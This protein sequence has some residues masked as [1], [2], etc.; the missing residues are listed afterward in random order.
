[1]PRTLRPVWLA[2]LAAGVL[3]AMLGALGVLAPRAAAQSTLGQLASAAGGR[4]FGTAVSNSA[5]TSDTTYTSILG[6][7]FSAVTPENA[8]KWDTVEPNQGQFDFSGGDQL[9]SYAKQHN[10]LVRGH[11]L[12]WHSQLPGWVS[13]LPLNQVQAA[14]ENHITQEVSHYKGSI[15]AWDVVNEPFNDDGS[16][17]SDVFYQA[18]GTGYIADALRTAHAADPS[19]K[20]YLNDYNIEGT[21]AKADAMYNLV[22]SLKAQGVP[23]DG[24]GFETHLAIQYGF[25]TGMQQNLQRFAALGVDVAI[26]ELDVRMTLPETSAQDTTQA[27]YY[28][29]VTNACLAVS[30]CVGITVWEFT[31]KYSWVPGTFSG[32][33]AADLYDSNYQTKPAY[34]AVANDLTAAAGGTTAPPTTAPPT[35]A[36][37]TTAPPTTAPPTTPPGGSGCKASYAVS[38]DWGSGFTANVTVANTGSADTKSWK[39]SWSWP[40]NQAVVNMW[41]AV[42]S[43]SGTAVT[44]TSQSYNA[45]IPP[46]GSTS[47]G[48]QATYSGG[49]TAPTLTCTAG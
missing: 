45:D 37:P 28:S 5:L 41:N 36:P 33:G 17:R 35:T 3:L 16:Y 21:G 42:Y 39:V 47:F 34:T 24:V 44:A 32:Q 29:Q 31:D 22:S 2:A 48:L 11:N 38:S 30:R 14:M 4:Y 19:A 49:N 6:S 9:V 13:G 10:Q 18:M 12:V 26:T 27:D 23:I 8:M 25:P 15:Y 43:Q 7:Q 46:G 40:G 1:M 20:L